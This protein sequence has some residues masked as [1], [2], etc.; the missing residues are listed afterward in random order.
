MRGSNPLVGCSLSESIF[1]VTSI[2]E[3]ERDDKVTMILP[4]ETEIVCQVMSCLNFLNN[5]CHCENANNLANH[6]P[7]PCI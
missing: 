2:I 7:F 3:K 4:K 1:V 6:C 5:Q